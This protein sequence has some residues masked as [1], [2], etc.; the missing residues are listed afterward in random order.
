ME[1]D[2]IW[3]LPSSKQ[4][5]WREWDGDCIVFNPNSGSTHLLSEAGAT[6]LFTLVEVSGPMTIKQLALYFSDGASENSADLTIQLETSLAEF[7]RIGLVER[8]A[9]QIAL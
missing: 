7:E 8:L 5:D 2:Q 6:V 3:S 9:E 1:P 4:L